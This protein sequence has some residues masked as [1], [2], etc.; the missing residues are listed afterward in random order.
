VTATPW[1]G[2]GQS[3]TYTHTGVV[4]SG[5][6]YITFIVR[7]N[8]ECEVNVPAEFYVSSFRMDA[9]T[10]GTLNANFTNGLDHWGWVG[11]ASLVE[12]ANST[13]HVRANAGENLNLNHEAQPLSAAGVPYTFQVTATIPQGSRGNAC[14]GMVFQNA[15]VSELTRVSIP[16]KPSPIAVGA[17]QTAGDGGFVVGL[18]PMASDDFV[19]W[20]D[21]PGSD[22]LWPAASSHALGSAPRLSVATGALPAGTVGAAYSQSLIAI[23]GH[24]PYVWM[25]SGLPPGLR[26]GSDGRVAGTPTAAGDYAIAVTAID[27]S[28][29]LQIATQSIALRIR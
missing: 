19:V 25:G 2:T 22:T 6:R 26:V 16:L 4:P 11:S 28:V 24:G 20:A 10:A 5:T 8:E 23:G 9:G 27:E 21:Y 18:G 29:P 12:V 3:I 1:T 14:L 15:S 7:A 17:T 13:L